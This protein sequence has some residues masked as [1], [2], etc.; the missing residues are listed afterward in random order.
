MPL[1]LGPDRSWAM[2][3][4]WRPRAAW[5]PPVLPSALPR[6]IRAPP[7]LVRLCLLPRLRSPSRFSSV[8]LVPCHKSLK[9]PGMARKPKRLSSIYEPRAPAANL[10]VGPAALWYSSHAGGQSWTASD[11]AKRGVA[12]RSLPTDT[13]AVRQR[14]GRDEEHGCHRCDDHP[15]Q[16]SHH[17]DSYAV[18]RKPLHKVGRAV[19]PPQYN[20]TAT[21]AAQLSSRPLPAF[22]PHR[23]VLCY[24]RFPR[25]RH[26]TPPDSAMRPAIRPR[27]WKRPC[28]LGPETS[29]GKRPLQQ[30]Q[31]KGI[32]YP[33]S[34][35]A[36]GLF[37][38]FGCTFQ[39]TVGLG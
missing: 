17:E 25:A 3:T 5:P 16:D 4:G 7:P 1:S 14:S 28:E 26:G 36:T 35:L 6:P 21:K 2:D 12:G 31:S 38:V 10:V 22:L 18:S 8:R 32:R 39:P 30:L 29:P 9:E 15:V 33:L 34:G 27:E 23:A 24:F 19:S 11:H 13:G 20:G 37:L